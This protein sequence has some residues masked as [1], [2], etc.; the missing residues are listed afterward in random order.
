[1][2]TTVKNGIV[3]PEAPRSDEVATGTPDAEQLAARQERKR[4]GRGIPKGATDIPSKGGKAHKGSTRLTHRCALLPVS[5]NL[6]RNARY[7][8]RSTCTQ[9]ARDVG[10]GACG[11][12]P[13]A[14][15]K[16]A[17]EDLALRTAVLESSEI[18]LAEKVALSTKLGVSIRGHLLGARDVAAKDAE[19]RKA[20]ELSGNGAIGTPHAAAI[21]ARDEHE[22]PGISHRL[23]ESGSGEA[24]VGRGYGRV[25]RL[26]R[27]LALVGRPLRAFPAVRP[28]PARRT[29]WPPRRQELERVPL[30][31]GVRARLRGAR[32]GPPRRHRLGRVRLG[33]ARRGAIAAADYPADP[34]RA[35]RRL[36]G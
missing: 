20:G 34:R 25:A 14:L 8:R 16:L 13:S 30:R 32:P 6:K 3:Y 2:P 27:A 1:M 7:M 35:A 9:L 33:L 23:R 11:I 17:S 31:R 10:G 12:V 4:G 21:V 5:D 28:A 26:A 15:V 29:G 24:R 36:F 19:A 22:H 18:D